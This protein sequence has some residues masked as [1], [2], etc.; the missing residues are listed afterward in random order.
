MYAAIY[1]EIDYCITRES[2]EAISFKI[3][4]S[5][6]SYTAAVGV[7]MWGRHNCVKISLSLSRLLISL[8]K[9]KEREE[10]KPRF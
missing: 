9:K 10:K 1:G 3:S 8:Q 6:K 7:R 4:D 5:T 2:K